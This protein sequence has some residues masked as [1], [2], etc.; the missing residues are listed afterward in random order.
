M[1]FIGTKTELLANKPVGRPVENAP[2]FNRNPPPHDLWCAVAN[3]FF[4]L[5]HRVY[6]C[7]AQLP[8]SIKMTNTIRNEHQLMEGLT[9]SELEAIKGKVND[10]EAL[11]KQK[12]KKRCPI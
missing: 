10:K 3:H 12:E 1:M 9:C 6:I 2:L 4:S 5:L 7:S 11:L 8:F